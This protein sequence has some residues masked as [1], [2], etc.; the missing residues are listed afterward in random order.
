MHL[1][2]KSLNKDATVVQT[3]KMNANN[4]LSNSH[5][6]TFRVDR[7]HESVGSDLQFFLLTFKVKCKTRTNEEHEDTRQSVTQQKWALS[8]TTIQTVQQQSMLWREECKK[9]LGLEAVDNITTLYQKDLCVTTYRHIYYIL[10]KSM[11]NEGASSDNL[12]S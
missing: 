1:T 5:N 8:S 4:M 11:A 6:A 12:C 3:V 7:H 9:L 2:T 10:Y